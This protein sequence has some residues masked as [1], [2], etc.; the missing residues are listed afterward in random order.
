MRL[1]PGYGT[2]HE[3]DYRHL[4]FEI[5]VLQI[6]GSLWPKARQRNYIKNYK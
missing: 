5:V 6:Y 4:E 3:K 1:G 2:E